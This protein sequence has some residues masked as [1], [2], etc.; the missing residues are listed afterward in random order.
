MG[1][2]YFSVFHSLCVSCHLLSASSLHWW[3][4]WIGRSH[5]PRTMAAAPRKDIRILQSYLITI[6]NLANKWEW[7]SDLWCK[8]PLDR[9]KQLLPWWFRRNVNLTVQSANNELNDYNTGDPLKNIEVCKCDLQ[10]DSV[11]SIFATNLFP[12]GPSSPSDYGDKIKVKTLKIRVTSSNGALSMIHV[13]ES[14]IVVN[15]YV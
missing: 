5:E 3:H 9:I 7:E 4:W 6:S 2:S 14:Q 15:F 8:V 12:V 11:C 1:H 13:I 10:G